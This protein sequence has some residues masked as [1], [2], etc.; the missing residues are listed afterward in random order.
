MAFLRIDSGLVAW[1]KLLDGLRCF[2]TLSILRV[3]V[4]IGGVTC[5]GWNPR[6]GFRHG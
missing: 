2:A 4:I 6:R 1:R 5:G 3:L